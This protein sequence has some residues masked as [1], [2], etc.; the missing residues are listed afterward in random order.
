MDLSA[1]RCGSCQVMQAD[2]CLLPWEIRIN[3]VFGLGET[4]I[5]WRRD[6]DLLIS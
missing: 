1:F 2:I 3:G 6:L 5:Y 4:H